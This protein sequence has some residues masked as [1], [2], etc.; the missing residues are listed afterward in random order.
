VEKGGK[1]VN[2]T[3]NNTT[4]NFNI[5]KSKKEGGRIKSWSRLIYKALG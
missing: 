1:K 4:A 3:I 2:H 5:K